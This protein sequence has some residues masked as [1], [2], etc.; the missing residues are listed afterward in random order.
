M[1]LRLFVYG[2]LYLE[3]GDS[4]AYAKHIP[5]TPVNEDSEPYV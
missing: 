1:E 5:T 2:L 4:Y 3:V